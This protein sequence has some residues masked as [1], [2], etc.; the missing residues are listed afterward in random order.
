MNHVAMNIHIQVFTWTQVSFLGLELLGCRVHFFVQQ[1]LNCS[2]YLMSW[3]TSRPLYYSEND[4]LKVQIQALLCLVKTLQKLPNV[5][6][7]KPKLLHC[8]WSPPGSV[9]TSAASNPVSLSH[10]VPSPSLYQPDSILFSEQ[11][12]ISQ[13][14]SLSSPPTHTHTHLELSLL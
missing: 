6:K 11:T 13:G 5:L 9:V 2:N 8:L 1:P 4:H 3:P 14:L 7:L 10:L 12:V